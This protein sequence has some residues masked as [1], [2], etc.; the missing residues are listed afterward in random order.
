LRGLVLGLT[1]LVLVLVVVFTLPATRQGILKIALGQAHRF[2]PGELTVQKVLWPKLGRLQFQGLVWRVAATDSLP[3]SSVGDTLAQITDLVIEFDLKSLR[4]HDLLVRE[5]SLEAGP[6]DVPAITALFPAGEPPAGESDPSTSSPFIRPGEFSLAPSLGLQA[7]QIH[8]HDVRVS[9]TFALSDATLGGELELRLG[10]EAA[11]RL[12][13]GSAHL[14]MQQDELVVLKADSLSLD[15][16]LNADKQEFLLGDFSIQVPDAG[17]PAISETWR[18]SELVTLQFHGH[19]QWTDKGLGVSLVGDGRLP[20][21]DHL[22]SI[23]PADFPQ[24]IGGPLLGR[25][26]LDA[27]VA[28]LSTPEPIGRARL[29]F[30]ETSWLD[31]FVLEATIDQEKAMVE[32]FNLIALAPWLAAPDSLPRASM[33]D[34]LV[35]VSNLDLELDMPAL[36]EHDFLIREVSLAAGPVNIPAIAGL[37]PAGDSSAAESDTAVSSSALPSNEIPKIPSIFLQEMQLHVRNVRVDETLTVTEAGLA[38]KVELRAGHDSFVHLGEGF[39]Q[40]EIQQNELLVINADSLGLD[41]AVNRDK[42]EFLL[43]HLM[44]RVPEAGPPA[45]LDAWRQSDMVRVQFHGSGS[46]TETGMSVTLVGDG[47]LPGVDHL[48]PVLPADFPQESAGPLIGDFELE[49][50]IS[51]FSAPEPNGRVRV[52]FSRTAWLEG[53]VLAAEMDH[54]LVTVD[55]LNL[56]A[57]GARL[58]ASGSVDTSQVDMRLEAG[59]DDPTLLH[60]FGGPELANADAG[61]DMRAEIRGEWPIPGIDLDLTGFAR[62]A[63]MD[64]PAFRGLIRTRDRLFEASVNMEQGFSSGTVALDS[65]RLNWGGDLSQPDSIS[66][67]FDLDVWAP[68][69]RLTLGGTG[70]ID[71]VRT[72]I[73]DSLVVVGLDSTM[74]TQEKATIVHGPGPRELRV[75]NFRLDGGLGSLGLD[76]NLAESGLALKMDTNLL[77]QEEFLMA[78]APNDLWSRNGG[79]DLS[80]QAEVDLE[81]GAEGPVFTGQAGALLRP[82]RD[83]PQ[84]GV[85]MKFHLERGDSGGLGADIQFQADQKTLFTGHLIWP[86]SLDL[87]SGQWVSDPDRG[88]VVRIPRQEFALAQLNPLMPPEISLAGVLDFGAELTDSTGIREPGSRLGS[89]RIHGSLGV[90]NLDMELPNGSRISLIIDTELSGTVADPGIRGRIKVLSGFFRIP[91]LSKNLLPIED[92]SLLWKLM[93]EQALAAG[94]SSFVPGSPGSADQGPVLGDDKPVF[95]PDL[96]LKLEIPGK[97]VITGYGLNI[98]LEGEVDIARGQDIDGLPTPVLK[99]RIG[100]HEGSLKFMNNIFTVEKANVNF[101]KKAPPNPNLDVK[102]SSNV[103]G[104]IIN[105]AVSGNANNPVIELTSEPDMSEADIMSVLLFGQTSN[106]LDNNQRGRAQEENDPASQ[107]RDNLAALAMVFGGAGIQNQMSNTIGVDMVEVGSGTGGDSTLMVGKFI[108]P[109]VLLQYNQSLEKSG[110]YFMTLEYTISKFF[111]FLS[112]YGQGEEASGLELKWTRRY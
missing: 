102:L 98:E 70:L 88:M 23:L 6:V 89:S 59:L 111:K 103:S 44:L 86:G 10:H 60:L 96:D 48:R 104:Y 65:L 94:D 82:H 106:E 49:A 51:D 26:E 25:F 107:M 63:D 8:V 35:Q 80:I 14:E 64:L 38:G 95:V 97:L 57:F 68:L 99:G 54:G 27:T 58:V 9:E 72:I 2:L 33:G 39:F 108:T 84:I 101:N 90:K 3:R 41:L 76:L 13:H 18:Q 81:G 78:L 1:G 74:R 42:R 24:E 32:T 91:E 56:N 47:E 7:M 29:D 21:A 5:V 20:G 11:L 75:D 83:D 22:R 112:T 36:R 69:G 77:L 28:D 93:A 40:V 31:S 87:E 79:A 43:D 37:F 19:G 4:Q 15:L 73:L 53:L 34:T 16:K 105:L 100:V 17:P 45:V 50:T 55:T 92:E 71:S 85:D 46:Y 109:R 110:T 62:T 52:D 67:R 66:H 12:E 61:L 30:S